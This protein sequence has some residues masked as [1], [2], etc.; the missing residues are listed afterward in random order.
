MIKQ[1]DNEKIWYDSSAYIAEC[2]R[3]C[4]QVDPWPLKWFFTILLNFKFDI[5]DLFTQV[6]IFVKDGLQKDNGRFLLP[7]GGQLPWETDPPGTVRL[8]DENGREKDTMTFKVVNKYFLP[9]RWCILW[10]L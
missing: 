5:I 7:Y 8:F 3:Y 1:F 4:L 10:S 2:K 6:A 9:D